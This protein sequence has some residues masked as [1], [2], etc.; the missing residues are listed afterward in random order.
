M[1]DFVTMKVH[2]QLKAVAMEAAAP[3]ILP[4]NISPIMSQGMGPK[5]VEKVM[6]YTI[7]ATR[8]IQP[9]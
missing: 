2:D 1:N 8:G 7:K 9:K 3:R 4:G 6:T 5:P